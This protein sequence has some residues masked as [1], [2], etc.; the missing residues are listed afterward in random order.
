MSGLDGG[1]EVLLGVSGL[2]SRD[3]RRL[4]VDLE[5]SRGVRGHAPQKIW[6]NMKIMHFETFG[7]NFI[8]FPFVIFKAMS[9]IVDHF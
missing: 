1:G 7:Y 2:L 6:I 3:C 5:D 4:K 9:Q 8:P